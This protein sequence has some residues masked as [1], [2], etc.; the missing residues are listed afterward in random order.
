MYRPR[1]GSLERDIPT[2]KEASCPPLRPLRQLVAL[3]L[4]VAESKLPSARVIGT[5][6]IAVRSGAEQTNA[7][8]RYLLPRV[9]SPRGQAMKRSGAAGAKVGSR[10][11]PLH[12]A[13]LRA[14]SGRVRGVRVGVQSPLGRRGADRALGNHDLGPLPPSFRS[15]SG[16]AAV[17]AELPLLGWL[18]EGSAEANDDGGALSFVLHRPGADYAVSIEPD[19]SGEIERTRTGL[20]RVLKGVHGIRRL[21][22][23]WLAP[24]WWI[25]T[26]LSVWALVFACIERCLPVGPQVTLDVR[27]RDDR[28]GLGRVRGSRV[29]GLVAVYRAVRW[30]HTSPGARARASGLRVR[31]ERLD[32]RA[33][34]A[35]RCAQPRHDIARSCRGSARRAGRRSAPGRCGL[36]KVEDRPGSCRSRPSGPISA[37]TEAGEPMFTRRPRTRSSPGVPEFRRPALLVRDRN[38]ADEPDEAAQ[39]PYRDGQSRASCCSR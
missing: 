17:Q 1:S 27:H 13:G 20:F 23:S 21:E 10:S 33:Q 36:R 12:R 15:P 26:E 9:R 5:T 28:G 35:L 32:D 8:S 31:V 16:S 29:R 25:Y 7:G 3:F 38:V 34:Q 22:G 18:E 11:P 39:D 37:R 14:L 6:G 4:P 30:L 2:Q 24:L 19:G